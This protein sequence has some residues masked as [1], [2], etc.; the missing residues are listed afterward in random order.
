MTEPTAKTGRRTVAK[1]IAWSIPV[2]VAAA[3][4]HATAASGFCVGTICFG[5]VVVHKCCPP[6]QGNNFYWVEVTFTNNGASSVNVTFSFTLTPSA[7]APV[8]FSGGGAVAGGATGTF[9][10]RRSTSRNNCSNATYPAFNITFS[11]GTTTGTA[12][13]PAGSTGGNFCDGAPA[14]AG[15]RQTPDTATDSSQTPEGDAPP[16]QDQLPQEQ[17][18]PTPSPDTVEPTPSTEATVVTPEGESEGVP[19][20]PPQ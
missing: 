2:V 3:P 6:G 8:T 15:L 1:G 19:Q 4:T 12:P 11:D 13:V 20:A 5:S 17:Q 7:S 10:V 9:L 16:E 14:A 18:D